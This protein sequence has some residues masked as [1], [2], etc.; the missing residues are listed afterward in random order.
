M[1]RPAALPR[2]VWDYLRRAPGTFIWLAIL[3]ATTVF[4]H[5]LPSTVAEHVLGNR[6]TNLHHLAEDPWRVLISSA[7]WLDGGGWLLYLLIFNLIHV[8]AERWLRTWRWLFVCVFVHVSAT[9]ISEGVLYWAINH[10][11]ASE[12]SEFALDVGVSYALVGVAAVLVYR[13]ATPWRYYYLAALTT[14]MT[15][16]LLVDLNFTAI[17]HFASLFL[18]LAC[19]PLTRGRGGVWNPA[20]AIRSWRVRGSGR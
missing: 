9:Y 16:P 5:R 12:Q 10:G 6:S 7:F 3:L 17:G 13:I 18:G 1:P 20:T 11:E 15:V 19:Y 14:L 8:P 4:L 2:L